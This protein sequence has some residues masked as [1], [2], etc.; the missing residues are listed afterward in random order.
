MGA[1]NL[2]GVLA[3]E[4]GLGAKDEL[5]PGQPRKAARVFPSSKAKGMVTRGC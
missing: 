4:A 2:P 1:K 3:G 5:N